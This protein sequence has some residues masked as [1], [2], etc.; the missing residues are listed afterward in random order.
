MSSSTGIEY[1]LF[2]NIANYIISIF[3]YY[4]YLGCYIN[5]LNGLLNIYF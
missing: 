3:D 2:I 5:I 1:S 4:P